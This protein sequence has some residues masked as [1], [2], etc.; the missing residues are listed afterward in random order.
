MDLGGWVKV[1]STARGTRLLGMGHNYFTFVLASLTTP[2]PV[3]PRGLQGEGA[4][5][6]THASLHRS[7]GEEISYIA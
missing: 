1:Y 7:D 2:N 5:M 3:T 4:I 6:L